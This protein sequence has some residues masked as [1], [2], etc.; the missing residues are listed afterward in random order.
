MLNHP[1]TPSMRVTKYGTI[2]TA[3][4]L[5]HYAVDLQSWVMGIFSLAIFALGINRFFRQAKLLTDTF[6]D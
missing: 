2:L 3:T 5:V 6:Y 4:T 1:L